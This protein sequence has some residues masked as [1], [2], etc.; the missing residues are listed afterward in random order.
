MSSRVQTRPKSTPPKQQQPQSTLTFEQQQSLVLLQKAKEQKSTRPIV[1]ECFVVSKASTVKLAPPV[2][3]SV[4]E[5]G[6]ADEFVISRGSDPGN[7]KAVGTKV[8]SKALPVASGRRSSGNNDK[9]RTSSSGNQGELKR[10]IGK[11]SEIAIVKSVDPKAKKPSAGNNDS[12]NKATIAKK[13]TSG[14]KEPGAQVVTSPNKRSGCGNCVKCRL[15]DCGQC[16]FCQVPL[17]FVVK[18]FCYNLN[19]SF[20]T[21]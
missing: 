1:R 3:K 10:I 15:P 20:C 17:L 18:L 12:G 11:K 9:G 13:A 5:L 7:S 14:N 2:V 4:T 8:V 6:A 16:A 21:L 19:M